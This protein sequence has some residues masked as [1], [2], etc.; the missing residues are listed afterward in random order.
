MKNLEKLDSE[1]LRKKFCR[2]FSIPVKVYQS[3]YF[4]YS[5]N[6]LN[7]SL[8]IAKKLEVFLKTK[9]QLGLDGLFT[10]WNRL[11]DAIAEQ[12]KSK[13]SYDELSKKIFMPKKLGIA[14]GHPYNHRDKDFTI[15]SIDIKSANYNALK[16]YNPE[17]VLDS[18]DYKDLISKFSDCELFTESKIFRQLLFEP[19]LASKQASLQQEIITKTFEELN[20][21]TEAKMVG[22]DELIFL[23]PK[24]EDLAAVDNDFKQK[25][26][27]TSLGHLLKAEA[28][29]VHSIGNYGFYKQDK[30][31]KKILKQVPTQIFAQC[32]KLAHNLPIE[33]N[34]LVFRDS[35]T[36]LL[37]KFLTP[38][39]IE[40]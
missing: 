34:D 25:I 7:D 32:Y 11:K 12:V 40:E 15:V 26:S 6:L 36:K 24:T 39:K 19:L 14:N 28:F 9:E 31:G 33:E 5:L 27:K 4:E 38:I 18:T 16:Y 1:N 23:L 37:S 17:L 30:D 20:L 3:P 2:D 10:E 29:N 22:R 8:G 21:T 13:P 35:E